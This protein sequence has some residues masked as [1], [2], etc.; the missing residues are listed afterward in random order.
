LDRMTGFIRNGKPRIANPVNPGEDFADK[1]AGDLALEQNFL[2]WH[3]RASH[4]FERL[5]NVGDENEVRK[6]SESKFG[7]RPAA[8]TKPVSTRIMRRVAPAV[9][10]E[11]G[12]KPWGRA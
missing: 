8:E 3:T 9:V 5:R 4:D 1:W 10:V 7:V 2:L 6:L 11:R 12:P